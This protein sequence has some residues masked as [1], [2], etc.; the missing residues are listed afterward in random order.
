MSLKLFRSTGYE[1]ILF[2]G[3]TRVAL[4]PG[5][6]I[7]A[8]SLWV[9]FVCNVAVWRKLAGSDPSTSAGR[10]LALAALVTAACYLGLS[11]LG[12]RKTLKTAALLLVW[13]AALTACSIWS[14]AIPVDG[15]LL[16]HRL[17]TL[18]FPPWASLFRWQTWAALTVLA[19]LPG[20]WIRNTPLR[21]L[22][23]EQQFG[24]N[25]TG[26]IGGAAVLGTLAWLLS[27]V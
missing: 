3:E 6:M 26:A 10:V 11:L 20:I 22:S 25:L 18:V 23:S 8:T 15:T 1:S 12:W 24:V 5:W 16:D 17:S 7:A 9:G 21:R 27:R 2:A 19:L 13:I 4:H 14:Q